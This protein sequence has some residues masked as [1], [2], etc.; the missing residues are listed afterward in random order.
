MVCRN[1]KYAEEA[2]TEIKDASK[3]ENIFIHILDLSDTKA[4]VKFAT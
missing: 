3:N 1:P 4:V 2:Q